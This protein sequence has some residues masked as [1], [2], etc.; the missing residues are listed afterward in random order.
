MNTTAPQ[1]R[2]SPA[3]RFALRFIET[4]QA[5]VS[6]RLPARCAFEPTCSEY[7]RQAYLRYGF[8][9]ATRRTLSRLRRC[10]RGAVRGIDLP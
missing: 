9:K 4:Y 2:L 6:H 7:G 3:S 8:F 5:G 1:R 10:R